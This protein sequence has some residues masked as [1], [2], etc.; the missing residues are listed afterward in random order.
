MVFCFVQ[1]FFNT[2]V[3]IFFFCRAKCEILFQ[4]SLA[5]FTSSCSLVYFSLVNSVLFDE[6]LFEDISNSSL[7]NLS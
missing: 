7:T 3:R 5:C 6:V 4:N 1:K 2:R